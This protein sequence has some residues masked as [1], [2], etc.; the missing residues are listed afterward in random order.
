MIALQICAV[1]M[2]LLGT[3]LM[4]KPGRW[5]PWG[6]AW[7][8]SNPLAMVFMALTGNW[9]F[10]AQHAVFFVLAVEGTWHWL[11]KPLLQSTEENMHVDIR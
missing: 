8:V 6:V 3:W 7:L 4:R 5:M 9:W 11:L 1:A 10:V 2:A